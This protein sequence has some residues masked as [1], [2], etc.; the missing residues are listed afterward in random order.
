MIIHVYGERMDAIIIYYF[1]CQTLKE[2]VHSLPTLPLSPWIRPYTYSLYGM[3]RFF[4]MQTDS[5]PCAP[6]HA[7]GAVVV[8]AQELR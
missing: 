6:K 2:R 4:T 5:L 1:V 7:L 8:R 3:S